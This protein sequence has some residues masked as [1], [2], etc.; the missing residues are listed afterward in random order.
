MKS[1]EQRI[2]EVIHEKV[3]IVPYNPDWLRLFDQEAKY[4]RNRLPKTLVTRIEHFGSTAIP[5]LVSKPIIDIL[6][7]VTSL[8]KTKKQI[9]HL[10]KSEGYDYFWRPEFDKPPMYAWFIKRNT[11][12]MR[13]YHIHMVEADSKLWDRL[14]FRDYLR[15]F[16]EEAKRYGEL[17]LFLSEQYPDDR[18]AYTK[19][20]TGFIVTITEK[21]KL[22]YNAT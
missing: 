22:Y 8:E 20:K 4:L 11:D 9:V 14:Y 16:P 6:V 1:L 19:G 12:G 2:A 15:E 21:A 7:E 3:S 17:K 5:G 10:L 13:T 18:V